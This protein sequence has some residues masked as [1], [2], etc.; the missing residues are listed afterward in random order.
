MWGLAHVPLVVLA[1]AASWAYRSTPAFAS[2]SGAF[3]HWDAAI[4]QNIAQYGYFSPHSTANST[5][6]FPGFPVVLTGA[7]LVLRNWTLSELAVAAVAGCFAVVS[8]TRL[9]GRGAVTYLLAFPAAVFLLAGYTETLFLAFAIPAWNAATRGRWY[10]AALLAGLAGV[11]RPD[12]AF[13]VCALMVMALTGPRGE[14]VLHA[15]TVCLALTGPALYETYLWASTGMWNAWS[16]AMQKGWDL[17]TVTP[18]QEFK[19]TW[20][21]S[22]G[23]GYAASWAGEMQLETASLAV[24]VLATAVFL[25]KRQWPEAVYCGLAA[26]FLGT[27]TWATTSMR[28]LMILFPVYVALAQLEVRRPWL[29]RAYLWTFAPMAAVIGLLF[30]AYQW[31]G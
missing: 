21:A 16:K 23:H 4:Y 6:F 26:V 30:L 29:R 12:G 10:R 13:L 20:M 1:W 31:A 15:S 18:V 25:W 9:G 28:T 11:V 27:Q 24:M 14:R 7:H 19:T 5:A 8:L 3:V 17:H 22:F 2:F